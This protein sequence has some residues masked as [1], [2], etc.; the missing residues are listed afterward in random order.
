MKYMIVFAVAAVWIVGVDMLTPTEI[1]QNEFGQGD[2]AY[3]SYR[4]AA[5]LLRGEGLVYNKGERVEG[6]TNML[7]VL[8]LAA[9]SWISGIDMPHSGY[10]L[11]V[12][13]GSLFLMSIYGLTFH[14]SGNRWVSIFPVVLVGLTLQFNVWVL[15]GLETPMWSALVVLSIWAAMSKNMILASILAGL[16]FW[17]RPDAGLVGVAIFVPY[18]W[19][20][21][22]KRKFKKVDIW[23]E[24]V[25]SPITIWVMMILILTVFRLWYYGSPVPNTASAKIGG[26]PVSRGFE[27]LITTLKDGGVVFLTSA[28]L[29]VY[30]RSMEMSLFIILQTIYVVAIGGDAF[31]HGRFLLPVMGL[32]ACSWGYVYRR[33]LESETPFDVKVW[34]KFVVPVFCVFYLCGTYCPIL[35]DEVLVESKQRNKFFEFISKDSSKFYT[36]NETVACIGIGSFGYRNMDVRVLDMVGLIT[37]EVSHS[38]ASKGDDIIPGHHRSNPEWILSQSPDEIQAS[39]DCQLPCVVEIMELAEF[40]ENY[41]KDKRRMG[42]WVRKS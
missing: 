7:W 22:S 12:I 3:I 41:I 16:C 10:V 42:V 15:S 28:F 30:F 11:S 1:L 8:L 4:Y 21:W 29:L 19:D 18:V 25:K 40:R 39:E 27:Y 23:N 5:N 24:W 38:K 31:H 2:D 14:I 26:I 20:K 17:T 13:F 36:G 9:T 6:F 37:P 34:Y 33:L 35:N 32:L